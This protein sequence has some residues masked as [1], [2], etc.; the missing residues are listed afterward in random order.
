MIGEFLDV[1]EYHETF[2][3]NLNKGKLSLVASFEIGN[4]LIS[5]P[6]L[7]VSMFLIVYIV[8]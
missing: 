5:F 2:E 3:S 7:D 6:P 8:E 1:N 4:F